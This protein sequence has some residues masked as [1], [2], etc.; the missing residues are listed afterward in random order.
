MKHLLACVVVVFKSIIFTSTPSPAGVISSDDMQLMLR[1]L[2]GSSLSDE[3]VASLVE[4]TLREAGGPRGLDLSAYKQALGAADLS[5]M[6][7]EI[8]GET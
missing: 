7:L 5:H 1:Q 2:G 4:R 8:P 6:V 3:E